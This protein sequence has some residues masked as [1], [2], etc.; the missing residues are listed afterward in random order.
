MPEAF[1]LGVIDMG[2]EQPVAMGQDILAKDVTLRVKVP[3]SVGVADIDCNIGAALP[4]N[5]TKQVRVIGKWGSEVFQGNGNTVLPAVRH[6]DRKVVDS[7]R[8]VDAFP[9]RI[10]EPGMHR[11]VLPAG[12]GDLVHSAQQKRQGIVTPLVGIGY[13]HAVEAAVV[14]HLEPGERLHQGEEF[15]LRQRGIDGPV[16]AGKAVFGG[17]PGKPLGILI[18]DIAHGEYW[19]HWLKVAYRLKKIKSIISTQ[20]MSLIDFIDTLPLSLLEAETAE[21]RRGDGKE[22]SPFPS[23][24]FSHNQKY[25]FVLYVIRY[26]VKRLDG[27]RHKSAS[28]GTCA[29]PPLTLAEN[30]KARLLSVEL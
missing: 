9:G 8:Q 27:C 24:R 1:Q 15:P 21:R 5:A 7:T 30:R 20:W 22:I 13:V 25:C 11:H 6:E 17:K 14:A 3:Y 16:D 23:P 29:D 19:L 2:I 12:T 18:E 4:Y 10:A 26:T 28:F